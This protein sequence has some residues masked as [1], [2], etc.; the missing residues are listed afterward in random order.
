MSWHR[1]QRLLPATERDTTATAMALEDLE[2]LILLVA[3]AAA[4][5]TTT[6]EAPVELRLIPLL[7]TIVEVIHASK[8]QSITIVSLSSEGGVSPPFLIILYDLIESCG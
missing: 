4:L 2:L 6:T 1:L 7:Q 5:L 3:T 8:I